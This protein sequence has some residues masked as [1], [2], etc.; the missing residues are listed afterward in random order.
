VQAHAGRHLDPQVGGLATIAAAPAE[1]AP[2][3]LRVADLDAQVAATAVDLQ[4]LHALAQVAGNADLGAV[5]GLHVDAALE[6]VD[7]DPAVGGHRPG[8]VDGGG[9]QRR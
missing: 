4:L 8:F 1:P 6:V 2:L 5:P 3:V 7:A 9:R